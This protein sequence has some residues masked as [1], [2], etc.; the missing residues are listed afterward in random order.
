[1]HELLI[2]PLRQYFHLS[3]ILYFSWL[4]V[5]IP[6]VVILGIYFLKFLQHLSKETRNRF[7]LAGFL[8]LA[9][10]VGI[11]MVGGYYS[12]HFGE[13][14]MNYVLIVHLEEMLEMI[15]ITFFIQSI[16]NYMDQIDFSLVIH[17]TQNSKVESKRSHVE[18]QDV[19][20]SW[21]VTQEGS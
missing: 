4:I 13:D 15:G 16:L 2:K 8:Y 9:G 21:P 6:I 5:L 1:M 17:F 19:K 11:E 12:N 7:L 10:A 18:L 3:G 20:P 14:N